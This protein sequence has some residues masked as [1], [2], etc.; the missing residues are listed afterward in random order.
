MGNGLRIPGAERLRQASALHQ[1]APLVP[2]V[3]PRAMYS[4]L[5]FLSAA[6]AALTLAFLPGPAQ[7]T[8]S[9][10]MAASCP[11]PREASA[12]EL[13]ALLQM[14][15]MLMD[16]LQEQSPRVAL[17]A[18]SGLNLQALGLRYSHA[19][20]LRP[21]GR[22]RDWVIRQLYYDCD[23]AQPRVFDEGLA[24]FV[25]GV[26][27]GTQP[28]L[29]VVW[30]PDEPTQALA[31]AV[32]D[33]GLALALLSPHYQAQAHAWSPHSQNCNQWL[34]EML[35]AGLGGAR[36]RQAAQHWLRGQGYEGTTL[37]LPWVGWR[38]AMALLPHMGLQHHPPQNLQALR[39]EVSMPASIE[40]FVQKRWPQAQRMEWCLRGR[41]VV[42]RRS[43]VELDEAC[44]AQADDEVRPLPP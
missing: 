12:A 28:R 37:Q 19:G 18:R 41:E 21:V 34:V 25:R 43:W 16:S 35:A 15:A 31:Q 8:T 1:T 22:G 40:R 24:A 17:I 30:W 38:W 20:W 42:V 32:E 27:S 5:A 14:T 26:A 6:A 10:A 3:R 36:N 7:A 44:N 9:A 13:D 33:D 23:T 39:L 11:A 2:L 29:S 4:L